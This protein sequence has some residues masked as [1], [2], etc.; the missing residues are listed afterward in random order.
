M[1]DYCLKNTDEAEFN[2]LMLGADL[3]AEATEK[4]VE[5]LSKYAIRKTPCR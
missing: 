1:T 4:Q 5:M 2:Q 3:R